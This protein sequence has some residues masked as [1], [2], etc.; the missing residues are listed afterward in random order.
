MRFAAQDKAVR[1]SSPCA[2]GAPRGRISGAERRSGV[3]SAG[4]RLRWVGYPRPFVGETRCNRSFA[5]V[6]SPAGVAAEAPGGVYLGK[7]GLPD[8]TA[9]EL[10][11]RGPGRTPPQLRRGIAGADRRGEGRGR[12]RGAGPSARRS[13]TLAQHE[14][15]R[16]AHAL[17]IRA[18]CRKL[19]RQ[20][21][22]TRPFRPAMHGPRSLSVSPSSGP[23]RGSRK[24]ETSR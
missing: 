13:M 21:Q 11:R 9:G 8:R 16:F 15:I 24:T 2:R 18:R 22:R 7:I 5:G 10:P 6:Q 17:T 3:M 20:S 23:P 19:R 14:A 12:R 4:R 1:T